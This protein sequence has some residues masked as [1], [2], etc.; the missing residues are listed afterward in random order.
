E[1]RLGQADAPDAGE[2]RVQDPSRLRAEQISREIHYLRHWTSERLIVNVSRVTLPL[3][4]ASRG[5]FRPPRCRRGA[6]P[7]RDPR[8]GRGRS[9]AR[10]RAPAGAARPGWGRR[11]HGPRAG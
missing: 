6:R 9:D 8:P 2:G 4:I 10:T 5:A 3:A 11:A 7:Q 1:R